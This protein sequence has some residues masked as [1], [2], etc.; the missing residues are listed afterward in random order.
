M[1]P[2]EAGLP[3]EEIWLETVDNVKLHSWLF[4][5]KKEFPT[6][7]F[8][9][10]NAGNIGHRLDN[11]KGLL[12]N[13][14]L[15]VFI[16]E[17]RGYG[18]SDGVPNEP[19]VKCDT[20]AAYEYLLQ[21]DQIDS[22]K[23]LIFG[24]SLGGC[25]AAYLAAAN[26]DDKNLKGIILEN[27]FTS[28]KDLAYHIL[29]ITKYVQFLFRLKLDTL[30]MIP[31][32]TVPILFLSGQ[33]DHLVKPEMMTQLY[34]KAPFNKNTK[35]MRF[36]DGTHNEMPYLNGYYPTLNKWIHELDLK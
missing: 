13:C 31:N 26:A 19:G 6:V 7:L 10:G 25:L 36:K 11:L 15:N 4:V 35:I 23:I 1:P 24:R 22:S 8:L 3:F 12:D 2:D 18:K 16:V 5:K 17:Y 30:N 9:H 21:C 29:P 28:I 33:K 34:K 20:Q 14:N 27:T 32:T